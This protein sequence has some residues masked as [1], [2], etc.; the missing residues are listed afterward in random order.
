MQ[1]CLDHFWNFQFFHQALPLT[2]L[3]YHKNTSTNSRKSPNTFKPYYFYISGL[4]RIWQFGK[5]RAPKIP[6]NRL[7]KFPKSWIWDQYLLKTWLDFCWY[8]TNIY[9]KTQNEIFWN[10]DILT[11]LESI[12]CEPRGGHQNK[13]VIFLGPKQSSS[14]KAFIKHGVLRWWNPNRF[15]KS[16][17]LKT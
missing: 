9:Y 2:P 10:F 4:P 8:G 3:N 6:K 7:M 13:I 12:F 14:H 1:Y 15:W 11:I 16:G 5:R 17:N